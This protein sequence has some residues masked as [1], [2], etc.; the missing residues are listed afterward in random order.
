LDTAGRMWVVS[1]AVTDIQVRYS[2]GPYST[3]SAPITVASG[4]TADD[5]SAV[6]R[7]NGGRI[8][9][10]W[11]NQNT[12]RF[13]FRTHID[14]AD[15]SV[16]SV[17][18]V[19]AGASAQA[20]G[21]G[22]ADDHIS[23]S[24]AGDGTLYAAVKTSYDTPGYP[25]VVLLVR[26]PNGIWDPLYPIDF[27]GSRP[28]VIV[29]E[30]QDSILIAYRDTENTGPIRYRESAR[31][32]MSF[33]QEGTFIAGAEVN[34]VSGPK[35]PFTGDLVLIASADDVLYS[36]RLDRGPMVLGDMDGNGVLDN[37]DIDPFEKALTNSATYM[38]I[39]PALAD[40]IARGD[41]DGNGTFN[42]FDIESMEGLLT[43]G[44]GQLTNAVHTSHVNS[45][46]RDASS[47]VVNPIDAAATGPGD[48]VLVAEGLM[49]LRRD[50]NFSPVS[51]KRP[52]AY[53]ELKSGEA[54]PGSPLVSR[55]A[56]ARATLLGQVASARTQ[57]LADLRSNEC[58]DLIGPDVVNDG[59]ALGPQDRRGS[60]S[61]M[62]CSSPA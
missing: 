52:L 7:L 41:A 50:N 46:V 5:I 60:N 8:G 21:A 26:R 34:N 38:S 2:D 44:P 36:A 40:Y 53:C 56:R 43:A 13:G 25:T 62:P 27:S 18:E 9:V 45:I 51:I 29:N 24:L 59:A 33:G 17:D 20:V 32:I 35:Q 54:G 49:A 47:S 55:E 48:A 39:Y 4:V 3:W 58:Q 37:F 28:I 61:S 22:M 30:G 31:A 19:P 11:S 23:L 16:W 15:P 12:Q 6:T 42:N 57:T 1:D 10:L 14:G